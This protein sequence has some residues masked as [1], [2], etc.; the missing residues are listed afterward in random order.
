MVGTHSLENPDGVEEGADSRGRGSWTAVPR[1]HR[2]CGSALLLCTLGQLRDPLPSGGRAQE[3][4]T[5][6]FQSLAS[7]RLSLRCPVTLR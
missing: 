1:G 7:L 3:A 6:K 5:Q 2:G 4:G